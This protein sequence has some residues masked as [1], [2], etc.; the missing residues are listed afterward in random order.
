MKTRFIHTWIL[1]FVA[2]F[3]TSAGNYCVV[4]FAERRSGPD[5]RVP[6]SAGASR[7]IPG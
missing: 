2:N 1:L 5:A 6:Y 7:L 4:T 3:A